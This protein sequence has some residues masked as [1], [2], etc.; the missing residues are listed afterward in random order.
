[1]IDNK[2]SIITHYS[3]AH[4]TVTMPQMMRLTSTSIP[5]AYIRRG[6]G[7]NTPIIAKTTQY[8]HHS[9]ISLSHHTTRPF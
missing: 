7:E 1:M 3:A 6:P 8:F 5:D 4:N 9:T 2:Q